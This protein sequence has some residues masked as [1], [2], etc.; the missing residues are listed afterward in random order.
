MT[1]NEDMMGRISYGGPAYFE[2]LAQKAA[3]GE[4]TPQDI[5]SG[6]NNLKKVRDAQSL[7]RRNWELARNEVF[8]TGCDALQ[9]QVEQEDLVLMVND[10]DDICERLNDLQ[11][12]SQLGQKDNIPSEA[13]RTRY[14]NL[15]TAMKKA[16]I[17]RVS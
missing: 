14:A 13:H 17:P 3:K 5:K 10:V 8:S 6:W 15:M 4:A 9:A 1:V 16:G 11:N 2:N 12:I 7:A